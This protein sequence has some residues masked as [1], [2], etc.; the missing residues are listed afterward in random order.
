MS[1]ALKKLFLEGIKRM[2]GVLV[3]GAQRVNRRTKSWVG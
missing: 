2:K 3:T 1:L